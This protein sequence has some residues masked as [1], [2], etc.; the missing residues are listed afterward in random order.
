[1][2]PN[3]LWK[4]FEHSGEKQN[5]SHY[6]TYCKACVAHHLGVLEAEAQTAANG[7]TLDAATE[8]LAARERYEAGM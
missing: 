2:A 4:F 3:V 8:M 7:V 5:T 6:K 1:M